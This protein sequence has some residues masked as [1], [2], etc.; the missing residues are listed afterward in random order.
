MRPGLKN[1]I[2]ATPTYLPEV[3]CTAQRTALQTHGY[4]IP[5]FRSVGCTAATQKIN[6]IAM[7]AGLYFF[8]VHCGVG[9]L[10]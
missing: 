1:N 9:Y 5:L 4:A 6:S 2:P 8:V 10:T 7:L 3:C